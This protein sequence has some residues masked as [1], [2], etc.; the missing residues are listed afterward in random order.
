VPIRLGERAG[1]R[2]GVEIEVQVEMKD[3]VAQVPISLGATTAGRHRVA[4]LIFG[5]GERR[6]AYG[7]EPPAALGRIDPIGYQA[8]GDVHQRL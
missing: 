1:E 5:S 2:L 8:L 3:V 6:I 7:L 4:T